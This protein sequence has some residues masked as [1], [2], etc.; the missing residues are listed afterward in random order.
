MLYISRNF[1]FNWKWNRGL[2]IPFID[3]YHFFFH[4]LLSF[5]IFSLDHKLTRSFHC[6]LL[7]RLLFCFSLSV[8]SSCVCVFFFIVISFP[9]SKRIFINLMKLLGCRHQFTCMIC[10]FVAIFTHSIH[11][12]SAF[13]FVHSKET[14]DQRTA[15]MATY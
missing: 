3:F 10:P 5:D 4:L 13:S 11:K 6:L 15:W 2:C 8:F 9:F 12:M 14:L 1:T 7:L